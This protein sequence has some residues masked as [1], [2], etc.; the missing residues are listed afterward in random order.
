MRRDRVAAVLAMALLGCQAPPAAP[1]TTPRRAADA[2]ST[3]EPRSEPGQGQQF[4]ARMVGTWQVAKT[5]HRRGGG[6]PSVSTGRCTQRLVHDGRFLVSEFAFDAEPGQP[7]ATGTGTIGFDAASGR[8]T[9]FWVDSR[10]TRTSVRQ[11]DGPF[12]GACIRLVGRGVGD[13]KVR[14]SRTE[15]VLEE[16]D[17]RIVHRQWSGTDDGGERLTMEL[18]MTRVGG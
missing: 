7:P 4:L 6:E 11:S 9:S 8:F 10:S 12:D 15:T 5:F 17:A 14:V 3:Y 2:Q 18:V 13:E 16:G 1:A